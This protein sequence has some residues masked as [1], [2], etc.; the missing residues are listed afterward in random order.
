MEKEGEVILKK[1]KEQVKVS[2]P[3]I[4]WDAFRV[5]CE[6]AGITPSQLVERLV[7]R[8]LADFTDP[9]CFVPDRAR[10]KIMKFL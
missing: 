9:Q 5:I 6:A 4:K 10:E 3:K 7:D 1:G 8:I 2:I